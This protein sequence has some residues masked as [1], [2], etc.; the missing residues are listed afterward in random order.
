MRATMN[1]RSLSII[2]IA[3]LFSLKCASAIDACSYVG[4]WS[5]R[6]NSNSCPPDAPVQCGV[7]AQPRCCPSGFTCAGDGTYEGNYCC[8][9]GEL[10]N[11]G[12]MRYDAD[13]T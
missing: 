2:S 8:Q 9:G 1:F 5:L 12:S 10:Q 7:G 3:I 13:E 4:G 6:V 11:S